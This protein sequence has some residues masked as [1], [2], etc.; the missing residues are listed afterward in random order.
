M[1]AHQ[2]SSGL[3]ARDRGRG[4]VVYCRL[5]GLEEMAAERLGHT[6][7]SLDQILG[8]LAKRKGAI[9]LTN[10]HGGGLVVLDQ[11][12]LALELAA[13][14]IERAT[15]SGIRIATG[16]HTGPLTRVTDVIGHNLAG[17]ALNLAARLAALPE[18]VGH[19][20]ASQALVA[21]AQKG[22]E[23]TRNSFFGEL[24]QAR[25]KRTELELR[26]LLGERFT[27]PEQL[28]AKTVREGYSPQEMHAVV[29][30][31]ARF[32]ELDGDQQ[33]AVV[34]K[35]AAAVQEAE[36]SLGRDLRADSEMR[37]APAGDSGAVIFSSQLTA[38]AWTFASDLYRQAAEHSLDLRIGV[39]TGQ[40]VERPDMVPVGP[41]VLAADRASAGAESGGL[42]VTG[43]FW[44]RLQPHDR[45]GWE[46]QAVP[47]AVDLMQVTPL[48]PEGEPVPDTRP[49][50]FRL[51]VEVE[52]ENQYLLTLSDRAG[53]ILAT[54]QAKP[55]VSDATLWN[56][57]QQVDRY[58]AHLA[59]DHELELQQL[60]ELGRFLGK[61]LLGAKI[62]DRLT[63][64]RRSGFLVV[65]LPDEPA[66][67]AER[68]AGVPWEM[69]RSDSDDL[70]AHNLALQVRTTG[71]EDQ[72][73]LPG[74]ADLLK[75]LLLFANARGDLPLA[76]HQE[77]E[78]L[79]QWLSRRVAPY[80]RLRIDILHYGVTR[81]SVRQAVAAAE[82]YQLVYFSGHGHHN[83][84]VLEQADGAPDPVT[85]Q[86][87]AEMF[88]VAGGTPPLVAVLSACHSAQTR[89]LERV[90]NLIV[91][92][93]RETMPEPEEPEPAPGF[94]GLAQTLQAAGV[95]VVVGM[96]FAVGD[97]FARDLGSRLMARILG[98]ADEPQ[99]VVPALQW[100]RETLTRQPDSSYPPLSRFSPVVWGG[101]KARQPLPV[102]AFAPGEPRPDRDP[103]PELPGY[104]APVEGFVGRREQLRDLQWR[105]LGPSVALD[106]GAD[107]QE[108]RQERKQA[109][110]FALILGIGGTGKTALAAE[111]VQLRHSDFE[112]LLCARFPGPEEHLPDI[113]LQQTVHEPLA[114]HSEEYREL[115]QRYARLP[116]IERVIRFMNLHPVLLVLD[117]FETCLEQTRSADDR[118]GY[119][120]RHGWDKVLG[121]L[122]DRLKPGCSRVL[123]TSQR[124]PRTLA[125]RLDVMRVPLGPLPGDEALL[126][127]RISSNL[128]CLLSGDQ[129]QQELLA[130]ALRATRG[131]PYLLT[132]LDRIAADREELE[133]RLARIE[134]RQGEG[135]PEAFSTTAIAAERRAEW[136]YIEELAGACVDDLL[137]G[138]SADARTLLRV[139]A[140]TEPPV[141][142]RRLEAVWTGITSVNGHMAYMMQQ[143]MA[144]GG[145]AEASVGQMLTEAPPE[146]RDEMKKQMKAARKQAATVPEIGPLLHE[147]VDQGLVAPERHGRQGARVLRWHELVSE[148]LACSE[149][150]SGGLVRYD[151]EQYLR[152]YA[153]VSLTGMQMA[154]ASETPNRETAVAAAR[155]AFPF[156]VELESWDDVATVVRTIGFY[157]TNS[158]QQGDLQATVRPLLNRVPAGQSR[159]LVLAGLSQA[160]VREGEHPQAAVELYR[161]AL[162]SARQRK[163]LDQIADLSHNLGV[164][165]CQQSDL[166]TAAA[167][168]DEALST[169]G[170]IGS[171]R[172]RYLS[173]RAERLR[174]E[175]LRGRGDQVLK[176]VQALVEETEAYYRASTGPG[177][178]PEPDAPDL[179]ARMLVARLDILVKIALRQRDFERFKQVT[180]R[181]LEVLKESDAPAIEQAMILSNRAASLIELGELDKAESDLLDC[182]RIFR[183]QSQ[184]LSLAKVL[185]HLARV[186]EE[187]VELERSVAAEEE[188]LSILYQVRN[189]VD[190]TV[191]HSNAGHRCSR[192]NRH[193]EA[194]AHGTAAVLL[195]SLLQ[196][197]DLPRL[198]RR[199]REHLAIAAEAGEPCAPLT[200]NSLEAAFPPLNPL[201]AERGV[202]REAAQQ[203]LEDVM[204]HLDRLAD[205]AGR[206]EAERR[207]AMVREALAHLAEGGVEVISVSFLDQVAEVLGL[208]RDQPPADLL[209]AALD[210]LEQQLEEN[211]A[212][213]AE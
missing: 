43:A 197:P 121:R 148:R 101:S 183:E 135:L 112:F 102:P 77:R 140:L 150:D 126:F 125:S 96:R 168:F 33:R 22:I 73:Q 192:L 143:M 63:R 78:C 156:L 66:S 181:Q 147:L 28:T 176:D 118:A 1:T 55:A 202:S 199:L 193:D 212:E 196:S 51:Q 211:Q 132:N 113:W 165:L 91:S 182:A 57:L 166:D 94:S 157:A 40:M 158:Q 116:L 170:A 32:S 58:L 79:R 59:G 89:E 83:R 179:T 169:K 46:T 200:V 74:R 119:A 122:R 136:A 144:Q 47:V 44:E 160:L 10:P 184:M 198:S 149:P 139:M 152:R 162:D 153:D 95:P 24:R 61:H 80:R 53:K 131:H 52:A 14:L 185:S 5:C 30:D 213:S 127:A 45:S 35:L 17:A 163:D 120:E 27:Q 172:M 134:D 6:V 187:R 4:Y 115:S 87:L 108:V 68:L 86:E 60:A 97:D 19:V 50:S 62:I 188:S 123:M 84:F 41:A 34:E 37:Y 142:Q 21:A 209:H 129:S 42:C 85:G 201:L 178:K 159:E 194:L 38:A 138:V 65:E 208:E 70:V 23:Q 186:F 207:I 26:L 76:L 7:T 88:T 128:S 3:D 12:G 98:G 137:Q 161:E 93:Y 189:V 177:W 154:L 90:R 206:A 167:A 20:A 81:R 114:I 36:T 195:A 9:P 171:G 64:S 109:A 69:A 11:V 180:T 151:R 175:V 71:S 174:V 25:V 106:R 203:A 15:A 145:E 155:Q 103:V 13:M 54:N 16:I 146:A 48:V 124:P 75:V 49:R 39:A 173:S 99:A 190:I 104:L 31:L 56:G 29:Y 204:S 82:G 141:E 18:A 72:V 133:Q 100:A 191:S 210:L 111:L 107:P 2:N 117:N 110:R 92:R 105:F 8:E 67:E 164:I 205:Q 130:R